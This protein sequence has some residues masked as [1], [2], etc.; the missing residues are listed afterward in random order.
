MIAVCW[1]EL[2]SGLLMYCVIHIES[3]NRIVLVLIFHISLQSGKRQ[4]HY[5]Y[6]Q[7]TRS[8]ASE[9][10]LFLPSEFTVRTAQNYSLPPPFAHRRNSV[11]RRCFVSYQTPKTKPGTDASV[12]LVSSQG[13][14]RF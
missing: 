12:I 8:I 1:K 3:S 7:D 9:F 13:K 14:A 6:A 5:L 2:E 4:I 10:N 11:S